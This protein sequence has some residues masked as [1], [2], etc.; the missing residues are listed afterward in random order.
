MIFLQDAYQARLEEVNSQVVSTLGSQPPDVAHKIQI[1]REVSGGVTHGRCYGTADLSANVRH[2]APTLTQESSAPSQS[3]RSAASA[4]TRTAREEAARA[5]EDAARAE[6]R[7]ARAEEQAARANQ[8]LDEILARLSRVEQ[9]ASSAPSVP[10][11]PPPPSGHEHA[12][13]ENEFDPLL[14]S[15]DTLFH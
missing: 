8:R 13:Y 5:R 12:D 10:A 15:D 6:E 2:H 3:S 1:W 4:K 9:G 14:D 11:P 7:A